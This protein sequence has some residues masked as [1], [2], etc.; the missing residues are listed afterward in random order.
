MRTQPRVFPL[1]SAILLLLFH[2]LSAAGA[3][4]VA[5]SPRADRT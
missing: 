4:H 1:V 5:G 2:A 3:S